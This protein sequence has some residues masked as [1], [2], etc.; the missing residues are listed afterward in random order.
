MSS[1]NGLP[2]QKTAK[3]LIGYA[4]RF[5]KTNDE[6][7]RQVGYLLLDVGVETLFRVFVTQP[8]IEAKLGYTKR[9]KIAKGTI[10]K[11]N[12]QRDEITLSGFDELAFH[13]LSEAVKQIAG[14]KV[15]KDDLQ[16]VEYFHNIRN[17]IYHLGDGIVPTQDNFEEY[18]KIAQSLLKTLYDLKEDDPEFVL[19]KFSHHIALMFIQDK[20]HDFRRVVAIAITLLRPDYATRNFEEHLHRL[21][22]QYAEVLNSV[23]SDSP[24][25]QFAENALLESFN[26]LSDQNIE[27]TELIL[28]ACRDVTYLQLGML[29]SLLQEDVSG[30][31]GKYVKFRDYSKKNNLNKGEIAQEDIDDLREIMSWAEAT[32]EKI[33]SWIETKL[34]QI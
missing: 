18:S 20:F 5:Q 24:A 13:K 10:E 6:F 2:W 11:T 26:K 21:W 1:N 32:Q 4:Q 8:G 19:Q 28:E 15:S 31:L 14:E 16:R 33:N 25:Y 12:I 3:N 22:D 7:E 27:D 23:W 17:K 30:G 34:T 9:D 29:L